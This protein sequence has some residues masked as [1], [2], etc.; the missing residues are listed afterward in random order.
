MSDALVEVIDL[1]KSY[2]DGDTE[3]PVLKGINLRVRRGEMVCVVGPSGVGKSTLLHLIGALDRPTS[4]KVLF[5]GEDVFSMNQEELAD[6]RSRQIGFIFQFHYLLPE[7]TALEN[8][9]MGAL[10]AGR[11]AEEA[12]AKAEELL[13]RVGLKERMNHKPAK[14]SGGERQRVAVARALVNDPKLIL[15]DEPTGN[16]D[17]RTSETVFEL[18]WELKETMGKTLIL[19][20]HD[21]NLARR[22]DRIAKLIDGKIVEEEEPDV[23][24]P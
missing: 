7:F 14:L 17:T 13:K 16:L 6:F 22:G 19:A 4:G 15:A 2:F 23:S 20:T 18:I 3:L 11:S 10:I 5:E 21:L 12:F 24:I 8:V 9:A 1:R